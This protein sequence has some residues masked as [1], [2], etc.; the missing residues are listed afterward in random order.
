MLTFEDI[1]ILLTKIGNRL[2]NIVLSVLVVVLFSL[3]AETP[4]VGEALAHTS[5]GRY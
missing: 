1:N 4:P 5:A 2:L 3:L